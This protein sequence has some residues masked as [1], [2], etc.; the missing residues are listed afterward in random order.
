MASLSAFIDV[1][2][3]LINRMVVLFVT[4]LFFLTVYL[5]RRAR[6]AKIDS[7]IITP[8]AL[9]LFGFLLLYCESA[10]SG[11]PSYQTLLE[12]LQTIVVL[13]CLAKLI[14]YLTVDEYLRI[15]IKREVPSFLR[16]VVM[17]VVYLVVGIL[18]LRLVFKIDLSAIA[19]TTTVITAAVAFGLQNTLA[20]AIS[21]FSI[22]SDRMLSTGSWITIKEKNLFG[23]IVNVGFRY[24]TLR[25]LEMNRVIVPNS[26]ILQ[27]IVVIQGNQDLVD[28][29]ASVVDVMLGYDMP[30]EQAKVLL[31]QVLK[32]ELEVLANPEPQVLLF[33][34]NDSGITYQL[35][36]M[37]ADPAR[38]LSVQDLIYTR[39]WY[40][41]NREGY[42]F[43][44][45]HRQI[46]MEEARPP[47][48]ISSEHVV[49]DLKSIDLFSMLDDGDIQLLE[50]QV[51]VRVFG[52]GESVVNQGD[53]GSS[54]FVVLKG[55]LEV[56]VDGI[57][58]GRILQDSFFG[59]MSLLTGA[60]RSATVR[61][62]C[63]VWLA[64]VT[65]ALMEPL[66]RAHPE[67]METLSSIL[68][69]RER[70]TKESVSES[71][72]SACVI[73][74]HEYY[75]KRLKQFFDLL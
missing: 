50:A 62:V 12:R 69:E 33:S 61:A 39:I 53:S 5:V 36:F 63:E 3:T 66:L 65:K 20:N 26:V 35:R 67:I 43:P 28:K 24:T 48:K 71:S 60:P 54:L 27:N 57:A 25:T 31:M 34:I 64:E 42:S 32:D 4:L 22:Q 49:Q 59:E 8:I 13:I 41:V 2:F 19:V 29:P 75:L 68:V 14:I 70:R 37:V 10:M 30:P 15:H 16:D 11:L 6:H 38:S 55:E 7:R 21:G 1:N 58:V 52:P 74:R 46:I 40:A 73:T 18:S 23:E 56:V 51:P 44:F 45:L 9:S 47:Y 72:I 17:I